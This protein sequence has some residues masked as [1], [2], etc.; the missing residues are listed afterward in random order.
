MLV[1][2]APALAGRHLAPAGETRFVLPRAGTEE[3]A[4]TIPLE[5]SGDLLGLR[6]EG[7][8]VTHADGRTLPAAAARIAIEP[9][10]ALRSGDGATLALAVNPAEFAAA[11]DYRVRVRLGVVPGDAET[12]AAGP[13]GERAETVDLVLTRRPAELAVTSPLRLEAR[14]DPWADQVRVE[15]AVRIGEASGRGGVPP[16][17]VVARGPAVAET[18]GLA[19]APITV[20]AGVLRPLPSADAADLALTVAGPVGAGRY[21]LPLELRSAGTFAPVPLE[22]E[23]WVRHRPVWLLAGLVA[24]VL[25]GLAVRGIG[26]RQMVSADRAGSIAEERDRIERWRAGAEDDALRE[27]LGALLATLA[28][29][30]ERVARSGSDPLPAIA[31]AETGAM[32][33]LA[34]LE[35]R[36]LAA[37]TALVDL[38]GVLLPAVSDPPE[39]EAALRE[40]LRR[41]E[42]LRHRLERGEVGRAEQEVP[43]LRAEVSQLLGEAGRRWLRVARDLLESLRHRLSAPVHAQLVEAVRFAL[44]TYAQRIAAVS[45]EALRET[46]VAGRNATTTLTEQAFAL[47][48]KPAYRDLGEALSVL[49]EIAPEGAVE[50][51]EQARAAFL[52]TLE[53]GDLAQPGPA[54]AALASLGERVEEA[55]AAIAGESWLADTWKAARE[56]V[57][58][59]EYARAAQIAEAVLRQRTRER[60]E[61]RRRTRVLEV[62]RLK[63]RPPAPQVRL[64][65]DGPPVAGFPLLARLVWLGSPPQRF[66]VRWLADG[67]PVKHERSAVGTAAVTFERPGFAALRAVVDLEGDALPLVAQNRLRVLPAEAETGARRRAGSARIWLVAE[68]LLAAVIALG[69]GLVWFGPGFTG[70]PRDYAMA[71]GFGLLAEL[72]V[73]RLRALRRSLPAA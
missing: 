7:V 6:P 20:A 34:D 17:Q 24:G 49:A 67:L 22:V 18:E 5:V 19:S 63:P 37:E 61:A 59:R 31:A 4:F 10:G 46:L 32:A 45:P 73:E 65:W 68:A 35:S 25:L 55:V 47:G 33:A 3:V 12:L 2:G 42:D 8:V 66:A 23:L 50:A 69:A 16:L 43:R 36:R 57:G 52:A 30:E 54:V 44:E 13:P 38:E 26:A 1:H 64:L 28:A 40:F 51:A 62:V 15:T 72:L 71:V 14:I 58:L 29:A 70:L 60:G 11:G 41:A 9:A 21:R 53:P 39:V 27:R 48:F 56:A